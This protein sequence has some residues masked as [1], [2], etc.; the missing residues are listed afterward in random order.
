MQ[1]EFIKNFDFTELGNWPNEKYSFSPISE[2]I[3]PVAKPINLYFPVYGNPSIDYGIY[4]KNILI[5]YEYGNIFKD[6][7]VNKNKYSLN[8]FSSITPLSFY[9]IPTHRE[10]YPYTIFN[11]FGIES[12]DIIKGFYL[13]PKRLFFKPIYSEKTSIGWRIQLSAILLG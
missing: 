11:V 8:L 12:D 13:N 7:D 3:E 9:Y 5:D 10:L 6:Y 1:L 4:S 2:K